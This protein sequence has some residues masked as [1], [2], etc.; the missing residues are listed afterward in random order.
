MAT[1][2]QQTPG[3]RDRQNQAGERCYVCAKELSDDDALIVADYDPV[4]FLEGRGVLKGY[5]IRCKDCI[6]A[7]LVTVDQRLGH[8]ELLSED[9]E[10]FV[11]AEFGAFIGHEVVPRR[12][13][14]QHAD[15]RGDKG[16]THR[17]ER[18][19]ALRET[20]DGRSSSV[21]S[22]RVATD[23]VGHSDHPGI[24][25]R[26]PRHKE[27]ISVHGARADVGHRAHR[28]LD[29]ST[30]NHPHSTYRPPREIA[31]AHGPTRL[32][33]MPGVSGLLNRVR[34]W[35]SPACPAPPARSTPHD[36]A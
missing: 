35:A 27:A 3:G 31:A 25:N 6:A 8:P 19:D 34:C 5:E 9:V 10:Q 14:R 33:G 15:R 26:R 21:G 16:V 7:G 20:L 36:T 11:V 28:H 1:N 18:I 13:Q 24:I 4:D 23:A 2:I 30:N 29:M 32:F 17:V 22:L 12:R